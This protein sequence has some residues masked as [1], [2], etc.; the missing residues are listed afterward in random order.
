MPLADT[1]KSADESQRVAPHP[2]RALNLWRAQTRGC[3]PRAAGRGL[4]SARTRPTVPR[5]WNRSTTP[6]R[7]VEGKNGNIKVT[8]AEDLDLAEMILRRQGR[9]SP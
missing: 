4:S 6:P 8:F 9:I 5:R 7:L 1:L 3:S 2:S